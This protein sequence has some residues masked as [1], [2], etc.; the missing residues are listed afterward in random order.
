MKAKALATCEIKAEKGQK[1][2]KENPGM[3]RF[4]RAL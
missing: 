4:L 3:L 1:H 2:W